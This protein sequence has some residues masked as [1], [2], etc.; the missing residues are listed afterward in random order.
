MFTPIDN[1][2]LMIITNN[3]LISVT[4]IETQYTC[5]LKIEYTS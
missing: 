3:K 1:N 5:T 4:S 2:L